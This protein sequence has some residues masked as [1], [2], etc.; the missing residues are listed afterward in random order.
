MNATGH[1]TGGWGYVYAAY[2][3]TGIVLA[4]Y[5]VTLITRLRAARNRPS[6]EENS[7]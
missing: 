2:L 1:I 4:V 3:W 6:E 5:T 7:R